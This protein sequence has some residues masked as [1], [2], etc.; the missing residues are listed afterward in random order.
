MALNKSPDFI[1]RPKVPLLM[2]WNCAGLH[3]R[4]SELNSFLRDAPVPILA[5]SEASLPNNQ[6]IPGYEGH[7]NQ[8]IPSFAHGSATLFI[9]REIPHTAL[10]V[11][12]LCSATVEVVAVQVRISRRCLSVVSI[13]ACPKKKV[14][15][16][17][18]IKDIC[19]YCPPPRILCGDFNVHHLLWGDTMVDTRGRQIVHALDAEN[20]CVANDKKPTF[21][22]PPNSI[23][24]VD[25]VR[26]STDT[27]RF[28]RRQLWIEWAATIFPYIPMLLDI[29]RVTKTMYV[30]VRYNKERAKHIVQDKDIR[31]FRPIDI[32]DFERNELYD[33][34]W[35]GDENTR[36][37]YYPANI[38]HMTREYPFGLFTNIPFTHCVLTAETKE[39]MEEWVNSNRGVSRKR[40]GEPG[41]RKKARLEK[42]AK[43]SAQ[44]SAE[45][46]LLMAPMPPEN[47]TNENAVSNLEDEVARQAAVIKSLKAERN[48][49][50][51]RN[52]ELQKALCSKIFEAATARE[53]GNAAATV[54]EGATAAGATSQG[55]HQQF[56][57]PIEDHELPPV[58]D[59]RLLIKPS[60]ALGKEAQFIDGTVGSLNEDGDLPTQDHAFS[61]YYG[62]AAVVQNTVVLR[63]S[64]P[65]AFSA[66]YKCFSAD[67]ASKRGR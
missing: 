18:L 13:Y 33:V 59:D 28:H 29:K 35:D 56:E 51:A 5:L 2:Q 46:E 55:G 52:L 36:G 48:E 24:V 27:L 17:S 1:W 30:L 39:E 9:R 38:L 31:R 22:R 62:R 50:K 4:L 43:A 41:P 37:D 16:K 12:D 54:S 67:Q 7:V 45:E 60:K 19:S 26:H 10:Q 66:S 40:S 34:W 25:L 14:P 3:S 44:K 58:R 32:E 20:L 11:Q 42:Q 61:F 53:H 63:G 57:A 8:T 15:M 6:S 64:D 21:F 65:D 23:S 47:E 49:L